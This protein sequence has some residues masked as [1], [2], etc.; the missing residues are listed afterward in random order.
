MSAAAR[1]TAAPVHTGAPGAGLRSP[2]AASRTIELLGDAWSWLVMREAVLDGV[3]RF[4]DFQR[5][6]GIARSTLAA[7]LDRLVTARLL[8]H[9]PDPGQGS[10]SVYALTVRGRDLFGCLMAAMRWGDDFGG[11]GP[12]PRPLVHLGCGQSLDAELVCAACNT[13]LRAREVQVRRVGMD[14]PVPPRAV[15]ARTPEL[16]LLERRRPCS[17]ARTLKVTGDRWSSLI[18]RAA[19]LGV[20]RFDNFQRELGI[21]ANILSQRLDRLVDIGVL[22]RRR[23]SERPPRDEYLLSDKGLALYPFY[24]AMVAWGDRWLT[25]S[26]D[27]RTLALEHRT[28]GHLV[29]PGLVCGYCRMPV[30]PGDIARDPGEAGQP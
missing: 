21:A 27:E 2:A 9:R 13:P 3:C 23:Y 7:R 8:V 15:R 29:D 18:L 20:R 16:S 10:A 14:P 12:R 25:R 6:L 4:D 24:L 30:G 17:I 11:D 22:V 26:D 19:F 28:C 5:R 1:D